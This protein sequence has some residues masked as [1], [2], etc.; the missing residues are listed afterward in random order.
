VTAAAA[1]QLVVLVLRPDRE[2]VDSTAAAAIRWLRD[3]GHA[4][5]LLVGDAERLGMREATCT[6]DRLAEAALAV[7]IGGDG[8]M[9]R[10]V[11]LVSGAGVPVLGVNHGQLGYLTAI[12]PASV[13]DALEGFFAGRLE[14]EER[15]LLSVRAVGHDGAVVADT[16]ALNEAALEK[17]YGGRTV[18]LEVS[19][20]GSPFTPYTADGLIV[21]PTCS[22]TAASSWSPTT[23]SASRWRATGPRPWRSTA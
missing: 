18:R 16:I 3:H 22:S 15:M 14:I 2:G 20:D 9:L 8:T 12:E 19:F 4:V 10:T 17:T 13:E 11:S 21:G 6:E 23:S 1:D 7:S 5:G